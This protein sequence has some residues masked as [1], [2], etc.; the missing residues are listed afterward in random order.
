MRAIDSFPTNKIKG[1]EYRAGRVFPFGASVLESAVNFSIYSKEATSCTLLLYHK[2]SKKPFVKIPFPDSFKIGNVY[3]M[4]V[5]AILM[6]SRGV[7]ML[8]SGDEFAN[9]QYGNNN[10]YC[11]DNLISWLDWSNVD[12]YDEYHSFVKKLISFRKA[13]PVLRSGTHYCGENGTGYP[14]LS[15]H[16]ET[17]WE[18]DRNC[19]TLTFAYMYAEDSQKYDVPEDSFIYVIVNAH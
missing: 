9:T 16:S 11:Q 5:L 15:F 14:E 19:G 3:T 18:L 13:H 17:P 6:S 4:M 2:C 1:I 7:P 8:L 12:K 10:A